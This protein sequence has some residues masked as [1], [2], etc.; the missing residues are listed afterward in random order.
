[1]L[2]SLV[3]NPCMSEQVTPS[4]LTPQ[5]PPRLPRQVYV[6]TGTDTDVGKT[7]VCAALL[8]RAAEQGYRCF[9]V[10]PVT[11]GCQQQADGTWISSDAEQLAAVSNVALHADLQAPIRLPLPVSPHLAAQ[12]AGVTLNVNRIVGLVRGALSTPASHVLIEGAGGWRVPIND[13]E[14]L[15]DVARLLGQPVIL[16]V[17]IRLGCLNHALLTAE[18][19]V[20]DGLVLAGWVANIVDPDGRLLDAQIDTLRRY[21]SAPCL[22]VLPYAATADAV[23]RG[24]LLR[25]PQEPVLTAALAVSTPAKATSVDVIV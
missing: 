2:P 17:G 22:G 12:A 19:I 4:V 1:M 9:G 23:A 13:R 24:R 14:T 5:T 11:A 15:A 3:S 16:V 7:Q 10:K 21:L 18:A 25:W 8:A 6:V 20:R